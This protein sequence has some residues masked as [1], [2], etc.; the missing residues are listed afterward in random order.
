MKSLPWWR[1][2]LVLLLVSLCAA[3]SFSWMTV[4]TT[5]VHGFAF[6]GET[7]GIRGW[8]EVPQVCVIVLGLLLFTG[9]GGRRRLLVREA[10]FLLVALIGLGLYW[11]LTTARQGGDGWKPTA[12]P[13]IAL[14]LAVA[15]ATLAAWRTRGFEGWHGGKPTLE[16]RRSLWPGVATLT[17]VPVLLVLPD[18]FAWPH[19]GFTALA[20]DVALG[21]AIVAELVGA[22]VTTGGLGTRLVVEL[23]RLLAFVTACG[24]LDDLFVRRPRF[25]SN[26]PQTGLSLAVEIAAPLVA[27]LAADALDKGRWASARR[28]SV[29]AILR[30]DRLP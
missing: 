30:V 11:T 14:T 17:G 6:G 21:L 9:W 5:R 2:L 12:W 15:V 19:L 20:F 27:L 25:T 16:R 7:D 3:L 29:P 4:R 8:D 23:A 13:W 24:L 18:L 22:G 10:S 28:L 26:W 1:G